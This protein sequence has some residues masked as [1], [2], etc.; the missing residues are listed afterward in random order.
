MKKKEFGIFITPNC[1]IQKLIS[2]TLRFIVLQTIIIRNILE[3]SCGTCEFIKYIDSTW[4]NVQITGIELNETV[5][6]SIKDLSFKNNVS[7]HKGDFLKYKNENT[8]DL[9]IGNPPYFV[10]KK[11][12]V[13]IEYKEYISGRPNI[14]GIFILHSIS[15][16]KPGGILAFVISKSFLNSAYYSKI[17]EYIKKNCEILSIE[18]YQNLNQFI[19]T[20]QSTFGIILRKLAVL[21]T[22]FTDCKFSIKLGK[23]IVFTDDS[24]KL[25][26]LL[27]GST[28]IQKIGLK[29]RTGKIVWNEHKLELTNDKQSTPLIYN[30]NI[31]KQNTIQLKEFKNKKRDNI[32]NLLDV[33]TLS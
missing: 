23:M 26:K 27:E 9:I 13:P 10:V 32:L 5:F 14:F 17:R 16:L 21:N 24:T 22:D 20:E 2:S 11:E 18:D 25:K 1:I 12:E 33:M 28:T 8:Y 31:T 4:S 30:T 7:L 19:D 6:Q 15:L 3:P 29:V